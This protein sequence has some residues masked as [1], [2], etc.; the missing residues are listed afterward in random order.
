MINLP[1]GFVIGL[2]AGAA[3]GL[4]W[5]QAT[6]SQLGQHVT[7]QIDNEAVRVAVNYRAAALAGLYQMAGIR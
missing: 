5:G 3:L 1:L 2:C 6:R 4:A 7:T